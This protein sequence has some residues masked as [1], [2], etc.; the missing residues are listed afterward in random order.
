LMAGIAKDR[1]SEFR[2]LTESLR[3]L[4]QPKPKVPKK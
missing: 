4:A 3:K 1:T 2:Y